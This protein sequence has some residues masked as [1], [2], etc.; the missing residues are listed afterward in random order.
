MRMDEQL[1]SIFR[2]P[3]CGHSGAIARRFAGT[4]TGLTRL[5]DIQ[6]NKFVSL[7]CRNCGF[8]EL[9]D[10][11]VLEGSSNLGTILDALFGR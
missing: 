8:T 1:A 5:L 10:P 6:H 3:K 11:T 9:Y 2:C 7:S 4:G